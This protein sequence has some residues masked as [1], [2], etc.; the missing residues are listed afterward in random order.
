MSCVPRLRAALIFRTVEVDA[1]APV[2]SQPLFSALDATGV[3]SRPFPFGADQIGSPTPSLAT[4]AALSPVPARHVDVVVPLKA[5][6]PDEYDQLPPRKPVRRR[7]RSASRS[8]VDGGDESAD[9]ARPTAK[10]FKSAGTKAPGTRD[11]VY[12][13]VDSPARSTRSKAKARPVVTPK[14]VDSPSRPIVEPSK[15]ESVR[16]LQHSGQIVMTPRKPIETMSQLVARTPDIDEEMYGGNDDAQSD[17]D[18]H[19]PMSAGLLAAI[20]VESDEP[21]APEI[22]VARSAAESPPAQDEHPVEL[23]VARPPVRPAPPEPVRDAPSTAHSPESEAMEKA[24][25]DQLQGMLAKLGPKRKAE[26]VK[27]ASAEV[28][29]FVGEQRQSDEMQTD[30]PGAC[31]GHGS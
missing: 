8:S 18:E 27:L 25:L 2:A 21:V 3:L 26:T 20:E 29:R 5:P 6:G 30:A 16:S 10:R 14:P 12:Q 13:T 24:F 22:H 19:A 23:E 15:L 11:Q 9:A 7:S 17:Y 28:T 1:S 4:T 31:A